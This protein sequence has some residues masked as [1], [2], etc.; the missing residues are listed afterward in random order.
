MPP[1]PLGPDGVR[2]AAAFE[3]LG[4]HWWPSDSY[5]NSVGYDGR[6]ECNNCGPNG[7]GCSRDAKASTDITYWPRAIELGAEVRPHCRVFELTNGADGRL[8][9]AG[10]I[11]ADGGTAPSA[12]AGGDG[13]MQR[14]WDAAAAFNVG[15]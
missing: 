4:W 12:G 5:I 10:Y 7:L 8:T 2:L 3:R 15:I 14:C 6:Q 1:L 9:G 11:D 13:G